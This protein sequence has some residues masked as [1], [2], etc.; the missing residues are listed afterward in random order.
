[1]NRSKTYAITFGSEA[2]LPDRGP[3]FDTKSRAF[4]DES[5]WPA[6]FTLHVLVNV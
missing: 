3:D 2:V 5:V 6:T 1:M 4:Q